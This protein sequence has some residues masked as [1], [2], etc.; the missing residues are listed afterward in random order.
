M[1]FFI[2]APVNDDGDRIPD[3]RTTYDSSDL[4]THGV[5]VGMTGSGKTGLGIIYLEEALRN[6]IPTLVIDPKGDM[7]NL[8]LTRQSNGARTSTISTRISMTR[9]SRSGRSGATTRRWLKRWR[10]G[11]KRRTSRSPTPV[12]SGYESRQEA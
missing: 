6:N 4:T 5:I 8:L 11:S 1:P 9:S 3:A 2:G 12:S 7:T 10:S